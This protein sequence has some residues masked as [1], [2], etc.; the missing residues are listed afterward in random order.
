ML[1]PTAPPFFEEIEGAAPDS[2]LS[3]LASIDNND[4]PSLSHSHGFMQDEVVPFVIPSRDLTVNAAPTHRLPG[5]MGLIRGSM[6]PIRNF[7]MASARSDDLYQKAGQGARS[8]TVCGLAVRSLRC[9]GEGIE[10]E[11]SGV[12]RWGGNMQ[13]HHANKVGGLPC[14]FVFGALGLPAL[15][16][17]HGAGPVGVPHQVCPPAFG[18]CAVRAANQARPRTRGVRYLLPKPPD[19]KARGLHTEV[20]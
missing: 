7:P 9:R 18:M 6:Q 5:I 16:P 10:E 15:V 17:T 4:T 2:N 3:I 1:L 19:P 11:G 8:E 12:G 14:R 20:G 13:A